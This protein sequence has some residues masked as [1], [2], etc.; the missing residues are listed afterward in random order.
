M[1]PNRSLS[2]LALALFLVVPAAFGV[3]LQVQ[4]FVWVA[5]GGQGTLFGP[6]LAALLISTGQQTLAGS[7]ASGCVAVGT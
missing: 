1:R 5:V 2:G 3:E 6:L 7:S 4:P